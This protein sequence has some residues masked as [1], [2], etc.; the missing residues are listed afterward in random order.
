MSRSRPPVSILLCGVLS[1]GCPGGAP[2]TSTGTTMETSVGTSSTSSGTSTDDGSGA[3]TAGPTD[4]TVTDPTSAT[5]TTSTTTDG[6]TATSCAATSCEDM[7]GRGECDHWAQDCPEGQKCSAYVAGDGYSWN[8]LKCVEV[9]GTDEPGEPCT[10]EDAKNGVDSCIEGAMCRDVDERGVGTCVALCTGSPDAPVCDAFSTCTLA[11]EGVLN[12]CEPFC[13]P[14][15][16]DCADDDEACHA[17][18]DGTFCG[19]FGI[20]EKVKVN[21]PCA[22]LL[23]CDKG[24]RCSEAAFVGMGC[25]DGAAECCTPYCAFPGGACP[26]PD[27]ACIQYF[28]P[29]Q[30]PADH[31]LLSVGVCGVPG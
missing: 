5:T 15:Q 9:T 28:D 23:E 6:A 14:V 25:Q 8:A 18:G 31:P 26:N 29:M 30:F 10:A 19:P 16:Q 4:G 1:L 11:N 17:D 7:E 27:Q 24:L 20:E 12:L 2:G 13:D 3:V 21:E 22:F